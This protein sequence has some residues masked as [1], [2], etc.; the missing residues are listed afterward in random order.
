MDGDALGS[1][2][3]LYF[4]LQKLGKEVK[5]INDESI[6]EAFTFLWVDI[7]IEPTLDI[8]A[9]AP[10]IIISLDAASI[11]QLGNTYIENKTIF[12]TIEF[13]VIDHHITNDWF[14]NLN[15]I[16][17][18]M[19]STCEYIYY[20]LQELD[21]WEHIDSHIATLLLMGINTDTNIYYNSNT[22]YETFIAAAKLFKLGWDQRLIT[23][24]LFKKKWLNKSK[25]WWEAL[26]K[27]QSF[28]NGKIVGS[29]ITKEMFDKTGTNSE[30][31]SGLLNEFYANIDWAKVAY[32][33]YETPENSIKWSIRWFT[34]DYN[35]SQ[36]A[37]QFWGGWHIQAAWFIVEWKSIE[38]VERNLIDKINEI[39]IL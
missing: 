37:Q 33:L 28:E 30:Q 34:S 26:I 24:Q 5:A 18:K 19:S 22:T 25:L 8:Q 31:T 39:I 11:G 20:I 9:F 16:D 17:P 13:I 35:V 2:G 14:G 32:L 6:P 29:S 23:N 3:W 21:L 15:L 12:D 38:E 7:I 10:D 1:L 36:I 4:I 27:S